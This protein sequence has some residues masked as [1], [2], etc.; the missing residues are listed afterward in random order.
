MGKFNPQL[1]DM[2]M[3]PLEKSRINQIRK[4]IAGKAQ[5]RVLEIGSGTG[6]NFPF[7]EKAHSV[8]AIEPDAGMR[9]R[10]LRNAGK[11]KVEIKTYEAGAEDL[12]FSQDTFDTVV[13]TLVFCTIPEPAQALA[14]IKRVSKP[15]AQLLFFEHVRVEKAPWGRIQDALTPFWSKA[16]A[17]CHLNRDTLKVI[18]DSGLQVTAVK[19][20]YKGLFLEIECLNNK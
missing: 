17:G 9:K 3:K 4:R 5:G 7:Y 8:H 12:P 2:G 11:A 10:S 6:A 16:F 15:G 20:S 1:Y 18:K 13:A 14:E 19:S